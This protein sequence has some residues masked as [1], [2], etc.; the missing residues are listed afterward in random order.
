MSAYALLNRYIV[1]GQSKLQAVMLAIQLIWIIHSGRSPSQIQDLF[2]SAFCCSWKH[3]KTL[4]SIYYWWKAVN[5]HQVYLCVT[6]WQNR[7]PTGMDFATASCQTLNVSRLL[8]WKMI[9]CWM[10]VCVSV[11][12]WWLH[13]CCLHIW[14]W[15]TGQIHS[16]CGKY[17]WCSGGSYSRW[18]SCKYWQFAC[19]WRNT[20]FTLCI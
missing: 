17:G 20:L 14:S 16:H 18:G 4:L 5:E 1:S 10:R 12:S 3:K 2:L 13:C 19:F 15:I 11:S 9:Q 6:Y 8:V 7:V